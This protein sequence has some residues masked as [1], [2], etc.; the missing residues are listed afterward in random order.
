MK[1]L[2]KTLKSFADVIGDNL[3]DGPKCTSLYAHSSG[4]SFRSG[5]G[6]A[7]AY[8][9]VITLPRARGTGG[10]YGCVRGRTVYRIRITRD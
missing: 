10:K 2:M 6:V 1:T 4:E 8:D 3:S 9:A 5:R 7:F